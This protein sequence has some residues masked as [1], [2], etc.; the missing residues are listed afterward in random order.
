MDQLSEAQMQN[1]TLIS[2]LGEGA[3]AQVIL[4]KQ[5][6]NK[7]LCALKMIQKWPISNE[8]QEKRT[9]MERQA[10]SDLYHPFII[11]MQQA[12]QTRN[13]FCMAMEYCPGGDMFNYLYSGQ[14][15]SEKK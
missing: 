2:K 9:V 15:F 13:Y 11:K 4:A 1:Y 14:P 5:N 8:E 3:F 7:T 6:L 10:L 12:F